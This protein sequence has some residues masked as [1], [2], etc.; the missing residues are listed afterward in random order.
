MSWFI[1]QR[2]PLPWRND[3][4][5]YAVW[6][7]EVMLQ[8]TQVAVVI[9]YFERW[10]TRFPNVESLA[11]A[12]IE[13]ILKEWEGLGYYSRA[14]NLHAGAQYVVRE[15]G[16]KLPA[17]RDE[18]MKIKGLGVYTVGA[19]LSFAFNQRAAAV[20]GNVLRVLARFYNIHESID[21]PKTRA[22]ITRLAEE[23]L[24][25]KE[26]WIASEALIELGATICG[27]TPKCA[28]CPLKSDCK[29]FLKGTA[30]QLPLRSPRKKTIL[31]NRGVVVIENSNALLVRKCGEG[32]IMAD[33]YEFP[34]FELTSK[35][36]SSQ[37]CINR[38]KSEW[39]IK[40]DVIKQME[41]VQHS[42]TH[43]KAVLVPYHVTVFKKFQIEGYRWVTFE[44]IQNL[45]FSSGHKRVLNS[46]S[47]L[48]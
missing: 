41:I 25:E 37:E 8:Q 29:G 47:L 15:H 30:Q 28:Q 40:V 33:L 2:R 45:P 42:F 46:L 39:S 32:K 26:P 10:M 18:L 27:K 34:Y 17:T 7:S 5:P 22:T 16:G 24:P 31:L 20:D 9:P 6:V 44:E 36:F 48:A 4:S 11:K 23:I 21:V 14:R 3:P 1:D 13:M 19:I 38:V 12:P 35:E 43:H